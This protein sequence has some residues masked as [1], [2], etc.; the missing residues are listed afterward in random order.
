[1]K[2]IAIL[3]L[4]GLLPV[5]S[6]ASGYAQ[7]GY[8]LYQT[9]LVMERSSGDMRQAIGLYEQIA[10][11]FGSESSGPASGRNHTSAELQHHPTQLH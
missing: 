4:V 5:C 10:A 11:Q 2:R 8:D 3:L 1:M 9:A 7:S 6:V